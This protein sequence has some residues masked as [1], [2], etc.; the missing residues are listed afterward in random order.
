[1]SVPF[2]GASL[3]KE[4]E[5]WCRRF[6]AP[7]VAVA[8]FDRGGLVEV[9]SAG[10]SDLESGRIA[11]P[12]TTWHWFSVTKVLTAS[13]VADAALRGALDLEE[14][15]HR[16]LSD[17]RPRAPDGGRPEI[18][19]HRLASHTSGLPNPPP[20]LSLRRPEDPSIDPQ[21]RVKRFMRWWGRLASSPGAR[22]RYSNLGYVVLGEAL[23]AAT[24]ETYRSWAR[25]LLADLGLRADLEWTPALVPDRATGY[26]DRHAPLTLA[27][28]LAGAHR[29]RGPSAG[30][31]RAYGPIVM[32][33][34]AAGG[35]VGDVTDVARWLTSHLSPAHG[36]LH[37]EV[38]GRLVQPA[39]L[40][41]GRPAEHGL[42]WL[43]GPDERVSHQGSGLGFSAEVR[44][45]P[46]RGTGVAAVTNRSGR[47]DPLF[48]P[49]SALVDAAE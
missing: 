15:V 45:Y 7:G 42:G 9:A 24:G 39:K 10:F 2:R 23:A 40:S 4:A 20:L 34:S 29:V 14:A 47:I 30:P 11:R 19:I 21:H 48:T 33:A 1:M 36:P 22:S 12:K 31:L 49:I 38:A 18:A 17:F 6:G 41:S 32:D 16:H 27:L 28:E 37:P 35:L 3:R 44:L 26:L 5:R 8:R 25:T 43:V 13:L 46:K